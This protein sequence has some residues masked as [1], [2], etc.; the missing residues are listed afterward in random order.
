VEIILPGLNS[1]DILDIAKNEAQ[2]RIVE[3]VPFD[4]EALLRS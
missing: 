3:S 1:S 2:E 4:L